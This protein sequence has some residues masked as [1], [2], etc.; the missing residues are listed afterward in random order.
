MIN[1]W[2]G[3]S[4]F[5]ALV[6]LVVSGTGLY[7]IFD[8]EDYIEDPK[9]GEESL[10]YTIQVWTA[11]VFLSFLFV[12]AWPVFLILSL[13][14]LLLYGAVQ[15]VRFAITRPWKKRLPNTE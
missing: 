3:V 7:Y 4:V 2:I 10:K 1:V 9:T 14:L 15:A 11:V 6:W 5:L 13:P 12:V 8:E